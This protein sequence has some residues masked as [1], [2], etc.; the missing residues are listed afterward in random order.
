[1]CNSEVE[2]HCNELSTFSNVNQGK[3]LRDFLIY[4]LTE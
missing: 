2:L 3:Q 4:F 1:M